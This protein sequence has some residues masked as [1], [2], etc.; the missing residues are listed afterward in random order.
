MRPDASVPRVLELLM[1]RLSDLSGVPVSLD[2]SAEIADQADSRSSTGR[3]VRVYKSH[4]EGRHNT[5]VNMTDREKIQM[6]SH[7]TCHVMGCTMHRWNE[8]RVQGRRIE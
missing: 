2:L 1:P 3:G 6:A 4:I 7:S 5:E 8:F